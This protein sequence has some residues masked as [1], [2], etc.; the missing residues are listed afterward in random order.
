MKQDSDG[1]DDPCDDV[2]EYQQLSAWIRY[3]NNSNKTK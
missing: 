1:R 3:I 2:T